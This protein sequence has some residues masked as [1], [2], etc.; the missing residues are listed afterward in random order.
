MKEIESV[1]GEQLQ[2]V[3]GVEDE[4][5]KN[6]NAEIVDDTCLENDIHEHQVA[7]VSND[8]EHKHDFFF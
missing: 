6:Q 5:K 2:V 8:I 7:N 3:D 4:F 1:A